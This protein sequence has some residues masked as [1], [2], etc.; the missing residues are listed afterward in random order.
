MSTRLVV[1]TTASVE[2]FLSA[3]YAKDDAL[4]YEGW[5][6]FEPSNKARLRLL[7]RDGLLAFLAHHAIT[8]ATPTQRPHEEGDA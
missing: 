4:G 3:F 2:A 8:V 6:D 5:E 1:L 7:A